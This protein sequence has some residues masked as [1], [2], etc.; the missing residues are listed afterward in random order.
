MPDVAGSPVGEPTSADTPD[1]VL[2]EAVDI[3]RRALSEITPARTIG[4]PAGHRVEG[5]RVVSLLFEAT[6]PGY[7]G[8]SWV[9]T[10]SRLEGESDPNVLETQLMPGE[11]ALLA[12]DWVPWS[13]RMAE[14]RA[15]KAASS[16]DGEAVEDDDEVDDIDEFDPDGLVDDDLDES[17]DL[18]EDD[19]DAEDLDD[20][21]DAEDLD[22]GELDA[23][24]PDAGDVTDSYADDNR[25]DS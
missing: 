25:D 8:W 24:D 22:E 13:E 19:L 9:V 10:L 3:A 14:Y 17:I 7:T 21:L 6:L 12:P 16:R 23:G 20:D 11:Q 5:E 18:G 1:R 2:L 15:A 4:E